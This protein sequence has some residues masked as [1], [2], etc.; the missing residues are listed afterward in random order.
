MATHEF[1]A[2]IFSTG[3]WNGDKY[4]EADLQDIADNFNKL[5]DTVKPPVRLGHRSLE[6]QPALGWVKSLKRVGSK[7]IATL[8]DVPQ[9][10]YD[11]IRTGGFKRVSS[12]IY[13][14]Y[15]P[16]SG[17]FIG[18][19]FNHVLKAVALLG[20]DI[21][22]VNN[23]N[24]LTAYLS[25]K[26]DDGSFDRV[27]AYDFDF[28][29]GESKLYI[30]KERFKPMTQETR[31]FLEQE[32]SSEYEK[33]I[34]AL[35]FKHPKKSREQLDQLAQTLYPKLFAAS[36]GDFEDDFDLR[37]YTEDE[38]QFET[39]ADELAH[40]ARVYSLENDV[41]YETSASIIMGSDPE[42]A[43]AYKMS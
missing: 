9:V 25:Q 8:S 27:A 22:A 29:A 32:F 15:K 7:L 13:L 37:T 19:T 28:N 21:P 2:E 3:T 5:S 42:L 6:G 17:S 23:L 43:E 24:D 12:E 16:R 20:A 34:D 33:K 4:S 31:F 26:S 36:C 1:D 41:D 40:R 30:N 35:K 38:P 10:I 18:K 11:S 39:P 14:K